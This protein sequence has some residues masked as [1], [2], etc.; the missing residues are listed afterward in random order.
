MRITHKSLGRIT[1]AYLIAQ[2]K[3][4]SRLS[5]KFAPVGKVMAHNDG[6]LVLVYDS[7]STL[8]SLTTMVHLISTLDP[9]QR[10]HNVA[11]GRTGAL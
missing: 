2:A 6:F 3:V 11:G 9:F 7:R 1:N 4:V 5:A 8:Q 10:S